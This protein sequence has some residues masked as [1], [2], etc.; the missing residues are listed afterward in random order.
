MRFLF[1]HDSV[2]RADE[3]DDDELGQA[4]EIRG[5]TYL[6]MFE[7]LAEEAGR[8]GLLVLMAAHRLR[9]DAWPGNGLWYDDEMDEARVLESWAAVAR[10]LCSLWPVFAVDL[11]NEPHAAS[12]ASQEPIAPPLPPFPPRRALAK[13]SRGVTEALSGTRTRVCARPH[14]ILL[15]P[16]RPLTVPSPHTHVDVP[17][18]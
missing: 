14:S 11:H 16:H 4:H 18:P 12:Y 1:N 13:C 2:L 8:R 9:P 10:S 3:I 6:R 17:P 5:L 15:K 7:M